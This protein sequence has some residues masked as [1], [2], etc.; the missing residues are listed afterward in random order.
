MNLLQHWLE[1]PTDES[2]P[3]GGKA[4]YS[5]ALTLD[6]S[7]VKMSHFRTFHT[8]LKTQSDFIEAYAA[9]NRI[10][11]D[12]SKRTG[13]EVF[14]Y[15]LF[16]VFFASC[17]SPSPALARWMILTP[18]S[19]RTDADLWTTTRE[20]LAFA[21]VAVFLITSLL[22][23]S[24]R[25][26]SVVLLTVSLTVMNVMGV[27]GVWHIS[28]NPISLVNLVISVGIAVEFCSHIAR[29]FMGAL[30]GGLPY[31]HPAGERDR[32]ERAWTALVDVGSSVS[33]VAICPPISVRTPCLHLHPRQVVS[34][35]T[36]TKLIGISVLALTRSK[37]LE[38]SLPRPHRFAS[39]RPS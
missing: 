32:D 24:F 3:L 5:S 18:L 13:G 37:L 26:G 19:T 15:S 38:V 7:S 11:A 4:G 16:Y 14:P 36:V 27:M 6:D 22:L 33:R 29:A 34:G 30:G 23:G 2:C 28:L 31:D 25:T 35:I 20:V 12:L 21:L 1:S 8:P 17:E 10:A 39:P 9:A